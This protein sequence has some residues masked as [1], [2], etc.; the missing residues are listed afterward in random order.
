MPP[1]D[2]MMTPHIIN[3]VFAVVTFVRNFTHNN[4]MNGPCMTTALLVRRTMPYLQQWQ[5]S[6]QAIARDPLLGLVQNHNTNNSSSLH[7]HYSYHNYQQHRYFDARKKIKRSKGKC[8]FKVLGVRKDMLYKDVKLT[9][10]KIAMTNHPDTH[11]SETEEDSAKMREVFIT[12]RIAF[13]SLMGGPDGVAI[14]KEDAE[15]AMDNFDSWFKSET[16]FNNPFAFDMDP[17]TMKEV[18]EMT[19]KLGVGL[20]RDGGM[21]TL[22]KMVS[23]AVKSGGDAATML[24]LD[25]GD[26][27]DD[28]NVNGLLRRRRRR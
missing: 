19:E 20:D 22:A 11:A 8:P 9:F 13:E 21:W 6:S 15:D 10:L 12:A 23:S 18:A 26:V 14:L 16:G 27:K 24:R 28:R 7:S 4:A 5:G 17:E 1:D 3:S 2:T 25:A